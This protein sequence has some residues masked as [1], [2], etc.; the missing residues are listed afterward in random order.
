MSADVKHTTAF[1]VKKDPD[2]HD[3]GCIDVWHASTG[4]VGIVVRECAVRV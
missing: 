4:G 3:V 2:T 1:S